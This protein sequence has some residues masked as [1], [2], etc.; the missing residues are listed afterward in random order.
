MTFLDE[1]PQLLKE[2]NVQSN[3]ES[4]REAMK[5]F[6]SEW[7]MRIKKEKVKVQQLQ[8]E[9]P[10]LELDLEVPEKRPATE[11]KNK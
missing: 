9:Y 4:Y 7:E 1:T 5:C 10:N 11:L 6:D 8:A 2:Y 3:T